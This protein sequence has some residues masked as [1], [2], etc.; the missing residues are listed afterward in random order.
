MVTHVLLDAD[1]VL[2]FAPGGF[3]E[4]VRPFL[5]DRSLEFLL[6]VWEEEKPA[7]EGDADRIGDLARIMRDFDLE[8]A[9]DEL[10]AAVWHRI[11]LVPTSIDLV[12]R[13]RAAGYGVHLGTNQESRRASY[14]RTELGFD[15]LFDVSCY[16]WELG[17]AKPDPCYFTRAAALIDAPGDQI[18]FVDDREP[19][20]AG[21]RQA[22][23]RAEQWDFTEGIE[24]LE[25]RLA[26][27][28]VVAVPRG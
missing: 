8:V 3:E 6:R 9:A 7:L 25:E 26:E 19:N 22:G 15:D 5:G 1:E 21:A 10:Y 28:G 18:V 11:E 13:L 17:V 12:H 4:L 14:M 23:L 2:Q 16:S 27:H 24:V 20:V